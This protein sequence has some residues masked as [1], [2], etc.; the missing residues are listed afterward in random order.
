MDNTLSLALV[1]FLAVLFG[2]WFRS[3][4]GKIKTGEIHPNFSSDYSKFG[5]L[6]AKG[7]LIQFST[8]FCSICPASKEILSE[9]SDKNPGMEFIEIDAEHNLDLTKKL[10]ILTTPTV[11]ILDEL[12]EEIARFT[13]RPNKIKITKFI[14]EFLFSAK[15]EKGLV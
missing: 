14:N 2:F 3:N 10:S 5:Q 4:Q 7:T 11:L 6:G 9:I 1:G 15:I 13:G 12:G 8:E